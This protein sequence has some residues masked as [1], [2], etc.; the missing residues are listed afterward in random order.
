MTGEDKRDDPPSEDGKHA[1]DELFEAIDHLKNAASILF[2]RAAKDPTLERAT[3]EADR[4]LTKIAEGA[5]PVARQVT[6]E[7]ARLTRRL[8][9]AL[10]E[11]L[12]D[13]QRP[14]KPPKEDDD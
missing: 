6:G 8:S 11:T 4:V 12:G 3:E 5:E 1:K 14:P 7:V 9:N 2:D 10:A 13:S